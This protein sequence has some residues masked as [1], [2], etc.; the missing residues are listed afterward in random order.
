[1]G[2][3]TKDSL[4]D[5]MKTYESCSK[6]FLTRRMPVLIRL[7]GKAFHTLTK[8]LSKPYDYDFRD[9][10]LITAEYLVANVMNCKLAYVQSDEITLLLVDYGTLQTDAWF[11]NNVQKMVSVSASM[12]TAKFNSMLN[13]PQMFPQSKRD[14]IKQEFAMFD[15]RVFN[16][17]REEVVNCF[18]WRQQDATRN[19]IQG[20]GQK[21]F[22]QKQLNGKSCNKIQDMLML[23]KSTNWN[24]V[25]TYFKRGGCVT[26]EG[27]DLEIPIFTQD[28]G[29]IDQY[30]NPDEDDAND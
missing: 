15:S 28:R 2:K 12:A 6:T 20:L 27:I 18:V 30:L 1:M 10:M 3:N 14:D 7:D 5:R 16:I 17:P 23:D 9:L 11:N 22:S 21:H 4:G 8:K 19:S 26:R 25:D 24:N 29:Y 13:N